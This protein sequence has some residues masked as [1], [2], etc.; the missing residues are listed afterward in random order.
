MSDINDMN[1]KTHEKEKDAFFSKL[2]PFIFGGAIGGAFAILSINYFGDFMDAH[3]KSDNV[4]IEILKL[5]G[6]ILILAAG[7][8]VHI[9]IHEA[10]HLVFGLM[11]GYSFISFRI[12]S[13]ALIIEDKKAKLKKY[14][15]PGT[16][17]Q[18]LM[19]PPAMKEDKYPFVLYNLGGSL[20][21]FIVA[22]IGIM[23]V[24]FVKQVAFPLNAILVLAG[25]GG[26]LAGL[27]NI[28]PMKISGVPNDGYNVLSM[29][30]DEESR[31]G[32]Y[33]QLKAN[34]LQSLGTRIKEMPLEMF[35]LK[36]GADLSNP[37]NTGSRLLEY[38]W[39]LDNMDFE[40]A[41]QCIDSFIPYIDKVAVLYKNEIN[42]ERIFLELTGACDKAVIDNL[43][44]KKLKKYIKAGKYMLG[45]K[46]LLMAYEALYNKDEAKALGY[47][48]E[49]KKLAD[50][51]SVKGEAVT[52]LMLSEWIKEKIDNN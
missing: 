7:Y 46:R 16:A 1:L 19:L 36:D 20:M 11:T 49:L 13:T 30:K 21:N 52:E 4:L 32:F 39:H 43:L 15:I 34:G 31:K 26:L 2:I 17:G 12:G 37:L 28:I 29:L 25:A 14:N 6:L 47:F 3:I 18:C 48:E 8:L 45:K 27:T 51:Y 9:I 40:N 44:D 5:Y 23:L 33:A 38:G 22:L 50:N 10:G 24:V 41:K 35:K 42:C